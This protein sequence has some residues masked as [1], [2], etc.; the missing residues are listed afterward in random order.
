MRRV[1]VIPTL[2][3]KGEGVYK[4]FK[5]KDAKY[6]GDPINT[7]K[8]FNDKQVD[9]LIILDIQATRLNKEPNYDLIHQAACECFMPL[10]YGGGISSFQIAQK[11][12]ACGV[13][14]VILNS[15]A[16]HNF[17]LIEQISNVYGSQSVVLNVDVQKNFFGQKR[18]ALQSAQQLKKDDL[19]T[20]I[21]QAVQK[22]VGEVML[23]A[24]YLE[25]TRKGYD[26]EL[27]KSIA[28]SI[29][30]P[31][32]AS[33]GAGSVDDFL[34]AI[35]AGASAVAAGSLFVFMSESRDS[36]LIQYPTQ[37]TLF[38]ELYNHLN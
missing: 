36:I 22:G 9:E 32:I 30:V 21:N 6:I 35:Q 13:E 5:F 14:K 38:Q 20:Y 11:V 18:L 2:L 19:V 23:N 3:I 27:I 24:V 8:I 25:A 31:L 7:L 29:S 1:R 33:A 15:H 17:E 4:T 16:Y 26:L 12:F 34:K 10:A 28:S 37:E